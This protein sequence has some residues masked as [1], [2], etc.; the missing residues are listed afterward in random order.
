V[1]STN[2]MRL[3]G[4]AAIIAGILRGI[5]SLVPTS[6]STF[7]IAFLYLLTDIFILFGMLG[8][9]GFQ[10][11]ESGLWGCFGFLAAIAGIGIIRYGAISGVHLYSIGALIFV[12]GLTLFAV[13]SW[14]AN[15]L[16]RWVSVFWILSTM[17]GICGYFVP[18]LNL[19]F[20]ISGLIFGIGFSGAGIEV[21]SATSELLQRE[22][23]T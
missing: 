16:P 21:W 5:S 1:S 23:S 17:V 14:I 18:G 12:G 6:T 4:L 22:I 2:L 8:L 7:A 13:G 10:Y 19:F 9:Y 15:K 20:V 11:K 3:G